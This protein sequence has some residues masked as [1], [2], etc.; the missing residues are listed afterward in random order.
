MNVA[1]LMSRPVVTV[2][3]DD[4]LK[5]AKEIFDKTGFHH[6]LVVESEK[7]FGVIS[8]RDILRELSPYVGTLAER[9]RDTF[10]LKK[11]AH[12]IMTRSLVTLPPSAEIREAIEIFQA[13]RISCI[14]VV[15]E[16]RV[17]VGI[18][19][20]RDILRACQL[21]REEGEVGT[22]READPPGRSAPT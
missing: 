22:P 20:W 15:D 16:E 19:S 9:D 6:L 10:T 11:K 21:E 13:H 7:L 4:S 14:P 2:G 1:A 5:T 3:L 17:P 12:Q 8:D 18:L